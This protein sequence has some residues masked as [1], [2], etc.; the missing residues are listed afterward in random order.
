M[1]I[2]QHFAKR[3]L[4][5]W[6]ERDKAILSAQELPDGVSAIL[7][8]PYLPDGDL[9]HFLDLYYPTNSTSLLPVIVD[10][11]GGGFMYG[12]KSLNKLY[13]YHLAKKGFLVCNINYRLAFGTFTVLDQIK[14]V[15][16]ALDWV[17][18][19]I[20]Q[21]HGDKDS[22][23]V[24]GE[25]AGA[26]LAL[27]GT[28]TIGNSQLQELFNT[29]GS[30]LNVKALSLTSGFFHFDSPALAYRGMRP[31]C[32]GKKYKKAPWYQAMRL[33]HLSALDQVPPLFIATSEEDQL[34][35]MTD[36]CITIL[37]TRSIPHQLY[38]AP[39]GETHELRHMFNLFHPTW[40]E[41]IALNEAMLKF[42]LR[43]RITI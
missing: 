34:K 7:D 37:E 35:E 36:Y 13:G 19:K 29:E 11:H 4:A 17:S 30:D 14:D 24:T 5:T 3:M 16:A 18:K 21:Y 43:T 2:T 10:I 38:V 6:D 32:F 40:E 39:K 9:G 20:E 8:I 15:V 42:F 23:F 41:S 27:V 25:S 28:L 26:V 1:G 12:D 33:M 31:I 22:V